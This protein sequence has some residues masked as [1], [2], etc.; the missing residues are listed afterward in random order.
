[1]FGS[2]AEQSPVSTV[3]ARLLGLLFVA[4]G[5]AVATWG[6]WQTGVSNKA[7]LWGTGVA[8]VTLGTS[9]L[10][11]AGPPRRKE[12]RRLVG[13]LSLVALVALCSGDTRR[14][15]VGLAGVRYV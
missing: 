12:T 15:V 14:P 13:A 6:F 5:V 11:S 4:A 7:A 9:L 10:Q 1:M 3:T 8:L 2:P